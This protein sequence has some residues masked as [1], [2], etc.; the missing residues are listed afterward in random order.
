MA[1]ALEARGF[2]TT[3]LTVPVQRQPMASRLATVVAG[4]PDVVRKYESAVPPGDWDV[5]IAEHSFVAGCLRSAPPDAVRVV[6]FHNLEWQQLLDIGRA[7]PLARRTYYALQSRRMASFEAALARAGNLCLFPSEADQRWAESRGGQGLVLPN[8]LPRGSTEAAER[9]WSMRAAGARNGSSPSFLYVGKLDF[10]PNLESLHRFVQDTWPAVVAAVPDAR[11]IVAGRLPAGAAHQLAGRGV[12]PL[13]FVDDLTEHMASCTAAL[14]PLGIKGGTS[15][16][17]LWFALAGVPMIGSEEAFRGFPGDVGVV[18]K[19]PEEWARAVS[20]CTKGD[21]QVSHMVLQARSNATAVN[22]G[23]P[24]W[25][26][27]T[28]A[29]RSRLD[30]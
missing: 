17:V 29:L 19:N 10:L 14:L 3:W 28:E 30:S 25:D 4:A 13:G 27:L 8:T 24:A 5:V 6:D 18:A 23:H 12:E 1:E 7:L 2:S 20:L 15:L 11:F 16:R 26:R 9:I 22:A 21:E